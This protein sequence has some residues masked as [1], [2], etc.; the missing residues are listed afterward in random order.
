MMRHDDRKIQRV[1]S[2]IPIAFCD[3]RELDAEFSRPEMLSS[4]DRLAT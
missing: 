4:L 2:I 1:G 3:Q